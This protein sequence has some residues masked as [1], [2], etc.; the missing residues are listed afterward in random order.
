[1]GIVYHTIVLIC[2]NIILFSVNVS[3][4]A[5]DVDDACENC[6]NGGD[7]VG[8]DG[9]GGVVR[10]HYGCAY[11]FPSPSRELLHSRCRDQIH[12]GYPLRYLLRVHLHRHG[13][14]SVSVSRLDLD[15]CEQPLTFHSHR[16]PRRPS[17]SS[18]ARAP[19]AWPTPPPPSS[20]FPAAPATPC[21][22]VLNHGA[23]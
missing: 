14:L 3:A 6:E 10:H 23:A 13:I 17:S 7:G 11:H 12:R 4:S 18:S 2:L 16:R 5:I 8:G 22:A 20:P 1:M 15:G 21:V 19:A 9:D